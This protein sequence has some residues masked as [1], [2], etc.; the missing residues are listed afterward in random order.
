VRNF[1]KEKLTKSAALLKCSPGTIVAQAKTEISPIVVSVIGEGNAMEIPTPLVVSL[2]LLLSIIPA[3]S[4]IVNKIKINMKLVC[5]MLLSIGLVFSTGSSSKAFELVGSF[6]TPLP[7]PQFG[8]D[9]DTTTGTLWGIENS[10][11]TANIMNFTTNGTF[12]SGFLTVP[13]G[14]NVGIAVNQAPGP[15]KRVFYWQNLPRLI[16]EALPNGQLVSTTQLPFGFQN[17]TYEIGFDSLSGRVVVPNASM[18]GT[19]FSPGFYF[20]VPALGIDQFVPFDFDDVAVLIEGLALTT[21]SY[22][23]LGVSPVL[24]PSGRTDRIVQIDRTTNRLI[25]IFDLPDSN[26]TGQFYHGLAIDPATKLAYTNF[27]T[28]NAS[29]IFI[30]GAIRV[31]SLSPTIQVQINIKP[32]NSQNNINPK[33]NGLI[34]VAILTTDSFDA[35]EVDWTTVRFG[36][37]GTEATAVSAAIKD[38]NKDGK[39]D[40][41]L[42]FRTQETSIDC[43]DTAISLSGETF[44]GQ[45]VEGSDSIAPV[46]C[47]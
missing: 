14:N 9:F 21:D 1:I 27:W 12:I 33:S 16:R 26:P 45:V 31:F 11:A 5:A 4:A 20:V 41:I 44:D 40:M 23:V 34:Q 39:K 19:G 32:G 17:A 43:D 6:P 7:W 28:T 30:S 24:G 35:A 8:L 36:P 29:G 10:T 13:E 15:S 38:L 42:H 25:R 37:T 47:K 22:W 3:Q 18:V 2:F 46:G